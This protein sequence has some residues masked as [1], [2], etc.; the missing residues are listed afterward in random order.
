MRGDADEPDASL[1]SMK[2]S[3]LF[4]RSWALITVFNSTG[5]PSNISS[6]W[7]GSSVIWMPMKLSC[8]MS[9]K[10]SISSVITCEV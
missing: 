10:P 1:P 5:W 7:V 9:A 4:C 8:S 2:T 3:S 6:P